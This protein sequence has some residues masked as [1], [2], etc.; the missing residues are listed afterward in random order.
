MVRLRQ[1][2]LPSL[3]PS[4]VRSLVNKKDDLGLLISS[5]RDFADCS[6]MCFMETWL[7][8]N[9]PDSALHQKGFALFR[10]DRTD[11]SPKQRGGGLCF[12]VNQRWCTV[13]KE[14]S[15]I[16]SPELEAFTIKCRPFYS[17]RDFSSVILVTFH[18]KPVSLQPSVLPRT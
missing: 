6:V 13:T 15:S 11:A 3:V 14:L 16:C 2:K 5:R 8:G 12:Y 4:N 18:H 1:R 10:P 17:A 7:D 9:L